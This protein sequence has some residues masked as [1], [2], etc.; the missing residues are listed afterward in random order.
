[1]F[2]QIDKNGFSLGSCEGK[3]SIKIKVLEMLME[4]FLNGKK[5]IESKIG[6]RVQF[7]SIKTCQI[8][9]AKDTLEG[10]SRVDLCDQ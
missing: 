2:L 4:S 3:K 9:L 5:F 1:M 8:I 6:A 7:R 10:W